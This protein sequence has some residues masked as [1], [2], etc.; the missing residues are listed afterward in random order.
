MM[1]MLLT[2]ITCWAWKQADLGVFSN[3]PDTL[4]SLCMSEMI[5]CL[6]TL[7]LCIVTETLFVNMLFR[8]ILMGTSFEIVSC[9]LGAN[10]IVPHY[11]ALCY[12]VLCILSYTISH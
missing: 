2:V 8:R 5:A 12:I 11:F 3:S 9:M 7:V 6:F 1:N 4:V 10:N